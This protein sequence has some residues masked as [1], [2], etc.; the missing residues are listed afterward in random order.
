MILCL[1]ESV[2]V[3]CPWQPLPRNCGGSY[4]Y[5]SIYQ[6]KN[7]LLLSIFVLGKFG[8]FGNNFHSLFD[9]C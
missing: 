5:G 1:N 9:V 7:N 4:C 6:G 8:F 3:V 2:A